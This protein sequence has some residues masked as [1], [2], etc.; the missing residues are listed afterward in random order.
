MSPLLYLSKYIAFPIKSGCNEMQIVGNLNFTKW[1]NIY[2]LQAFFLS[3]LS[4]YTL[5][6]S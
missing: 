3:V 1:Q 2:N 4:L 6:S 5:N